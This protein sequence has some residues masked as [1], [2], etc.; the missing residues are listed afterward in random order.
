[1]RLALA[2]SAMVVL[3]GSHATVR[4]A[5]AQSA[6]LD[7]RAPYIR[8]LDALRASDSVLPP[9]L[10]RVELYG[11]YNREAPVPPQC[12]TRTE[13][14]HNPCYVCHQNA[15][16]GREN[17]M[18]D[19]D[20]QKEYRFSETGTSNHWS[21]LFKDR[22]A[23]V[24]RIS[25]ADILSW[26]GQDNYSE[27]PAR[28]EA[29]DFK[30]WIPD[31]A[32]LQDG[33]EAFDESGFARDR[34]GWVA[35][36]YKPLPS[37][38]W[39]TNGAT[40]DVMIRLPE[41]FRQD[42]KRLPSRDVYAANLG[43]LEAN[44]KA[45]QWIGTLPI[46]ERKV[47]VDLD[48]DGH[49][50]RVQRIRA[51]ASYVG[52][53]QAIAAEP[54]IFPEGTEFLHTV[55]YVGVN[56]RG[57]IVPSRRIK[58]VRYMRRWL[59]SSREDL[60]TWYEAENIEKNQGELPAYV[61]F[62]H[63]GLG[64]PMGWQI[65]GFIEDRNGRLRANTFEETMFCMGCH[66]SIGTTVDKTFSFVRKRDGAAGWGYINLHG[67]A[68]APNVGETRGEIAT[69]LERVGGGSEFRS[70]PEMQARWYRADGTV[71]FDAVLSARDVYDLI[72]PSRERAL[73][74]NKA[75][76]VIVSE[77]SYIFGRDPTV[78]PPKNVY[79]V[80]RAENAPTLP[81]T[82]QFKWNMQLDWHPAAAR[83]LLTDGRR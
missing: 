10:P 55:R 45:T 76:R 9:R 33:A 6:S 36:N 68:D 78:T 66:N 30:G 19:F 65:S 12:Y 14:Q 67:M 25:D 17:V 1:M 81:D 5:E 34:S 49:L 57:E 59:A 38:F 69:Y 18:N 61:N 51:R 20:L 4:S 83:G 50:A 31:L 63:R 8:I 53:A 46:D 13:G 82:R 41:A 48:G 62:G 72:T 77:Q 27:L 58:E 26:I 11:M 75:Y 37:T 79:D 74:L 39:P 16:P 60:K 23:D 32:N 40:D 71:N 28:L 21:N 42:A 3:A 64:G 56:A 70:N 24:A 29:A 52:G 47:G 73:M 22:S 44:I 43:I 7:A 35:I 15:L 80:V 2:M 54:S